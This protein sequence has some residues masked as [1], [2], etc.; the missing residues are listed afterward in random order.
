MDNAVNLSS[1]CSLCF[2]PRPYPVVPRTL[3]VQSVYILR[4]CEKKKKGGQ[5]KHNSLSIDMTSYAC[6]VF[7]YLRPLAVCFLHS[8]MRYECMDYDFFCACLLQS[9]LEHRTSTN[10][11]VHT[12]KTLHTTIRTEPGKHIYIYIP[13]PIHTP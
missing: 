13:I 6:F 11:V 2:L 9:M 8:F 5:V 12:N 3:A 7:G 1:V 4:Y 10:L